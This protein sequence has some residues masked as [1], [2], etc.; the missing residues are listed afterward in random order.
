MPVGRERPPEGRAWGEEGGSQ[1]V[2][3]HAPLSICSAATTASTATPAAK[4][5]AGSSA[6]IRRL[7]RTW[8]VRMSA[9]GAMTLVTV[10]RDGFSVGGTVLSSFGSP[11]LFP[12]EVFG[13]GNQGLD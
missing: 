8:T 3:A 1:M 2:V 4:S 7:A 11:H 13:D 5:A 10:Q 9:I 12:S 6:P